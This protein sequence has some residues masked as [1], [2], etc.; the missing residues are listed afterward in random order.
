MKRQHLGVTRRELLTAGGVT[1]AALTLQQVLAR[2]PGLAAEFL[3]YSRLADEPAPG[4][5]LK[6][7]VVYTVDGSYSMAQAIAVRGGLITAV[8]TDSA[9]EALAGPR[10][11]IIDLEGRSVTPGLIDPHVHFRSVGLNYRYYIPFMP[12]EVND[13]PSLQEAI[14]SAVETVEPG[15]WLMCY[16]M[17]LLDQSI[18]LKEDLDPVSPNNPVFIMHIGGHWATANS[19]AL[20][21]AGVTSSTPSPEGGIIEKDEH[22]EL[23]GVLYNHRAMDVVRQYAPP[24][25]EEDVRQSILTTQDLMAAFGVT[26]FQDNNIRDLDDIRAYQELS[27]EGVLKLRNALYLTLEWPTDMSKLAEV[28][29]INNDVTRFAGCKF[30]IDGQGPTAYCHQPHNGAEYRLPTWDPTTYKQAVRMIHN[31]GLQV[32]THCI[33]DAAADLVLEAYEGAMNANPRSDPRH[34]LEHAVLTTSQATRKMADLGTILSTNPAFIYLFGGGWESLYG[35]ERM[36]RIMVTREWLD[37]GLHVTIGSDAPSTPF[38]QPQ[39]TLAGAISRLTYGETVLGP[40]QALSFDEALRAHTIEAAYAAHEEDVKGSLE[41]GKFADIAVWAVDPATTPVSELP[42]Q[43][44][45]YMTFVGGRLVFP[46][47]RNHLPFV[48]S[49]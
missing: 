9:I 17:V 32:C 22:G 39:Y 1:L 21:A 11:R 43:G 3:S 16:Y 35:T 5:I 40:D 12:P 46:L 18:P 45:M 44:A 23:T 31:Q 26:S 48:Q 29:R 33:G 37:A 6:N 34:R 7:G 19:A 47:N 25:T 15:E 27:A 10:T 42:E 28:Q 4:L 41:A 14:E 30:L 49:A 38:Y 2:R 8:G 13:I 20:L 36:S 24:I